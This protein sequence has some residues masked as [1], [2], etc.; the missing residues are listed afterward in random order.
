MSDDHSRGKQPE[1]PVERVQDGIA[2]ITA[3]GTAMGSSAEDIELSV[4][5]HRRV[6]E[7]S[8]ERYRA[9]WKGITLEARIRYVQPGLFV[10]LMSGYADSAR[11][12]SSA[13]AAFIQK[14]FTMPAL[15]AE[16]RRVI[17]RD[18]PPSE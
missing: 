16:V 14:P 1:W 9:T 5:M 11:P 12:M 6:L 13:V 3:A 17:A 18:R 7:G 8:T 2:D 4:A 15:L 10:I